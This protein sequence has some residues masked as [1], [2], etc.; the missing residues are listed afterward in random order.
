MYVRHAFEKEESHT[1]FALYLVH[2]LGC[3][4]VDVENFNAPKVNFV[5]LMLLK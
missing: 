3:A 4:V 1:L 2:L 5:I